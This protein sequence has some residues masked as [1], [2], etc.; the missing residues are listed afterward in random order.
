MCN[1]VLCCFSAIESTRQEQASRNWEEQAQAELTAQRDLHR[2]V[3]STIQVNT[4][5]AQKGRNREIWNKFN[6]T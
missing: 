6:L 4:G 2:Q 5:W 3:M 1:G